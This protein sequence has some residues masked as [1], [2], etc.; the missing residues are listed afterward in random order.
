MHRFD[1]AGAEIERI[2]TKCACCACV[3]F[4]FHPVKL[5]VSK[6]RPYKTYRA[7]RQFGKSAIRKPLLIQ[8]SKNTFPNYSNCPRFVS[9]DDVSWS[10]LYLLSQFI[11][12]FSY[13]RSHHVCA[14]CTCST[15][16]YRHNESSLFKC[17]NSNPFP[18]RE[19]K[20]HE[21]I[22]SQSEHAHSHKHTFV[23]ELM[24]LVAK[25]R[26]H[27]SKHMQHK[28]PICNYVD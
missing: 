13:C 18:T 23:F 28:K 24:I 14:H 10:C 12:F 3:S 1:V 17:A 19:I 7:E 20:T 27:Q 26:T 21:Y 4:V 15:I 25:T 9:S 16:C 2:N 6:L 22:T 11:R 8:N 5:T